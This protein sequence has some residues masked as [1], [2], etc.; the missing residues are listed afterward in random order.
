VERFGAT[1]RL[2]APAEGPLGRIDSPEQ[3]ALTARASIYVSTAVVQPWMVFQTDLMLA[4][5]ELGEEDTPVGLKP[6]P[7]TPTPTPEARA[8][9]V[10]SLW[11]GLDA[12]LENL[13]G[14]IQDELG[15]A[16]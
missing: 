1:G 14:A 13:M 10:R 9:L 5:I 15:L 16:E 12:D 3:A 6:M 11:R 8:E 2:T 4:R 7:P